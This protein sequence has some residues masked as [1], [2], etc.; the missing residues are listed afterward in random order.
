MKEI[1][2]DEETLNLEILIQVTLTPKGEQRPPKAAMKRVQLKTLRSRQLIKAKQ[3]KPRGICNLVPVWKRG[4]LKS[5]VSH[6]LNFKSWI[7]L[8][9]G[10]V[11]KCNFVI[12]EFNP[13]SEVQNIENGVFQNARFPNTPFANCHFPNW[14][15]SCLWAVWCKMAF[16]KKAYPKVKLLSRP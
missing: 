14:D 11:D 15:Y 1:R 8:I 7:K 12:N 2:M 16:F 13:T 3:A 4:I 10:T 6:V 5:L 9:Y